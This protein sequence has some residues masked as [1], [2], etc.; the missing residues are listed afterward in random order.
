MLF[1]F[2]FALK[3]NYRDFGAN[4]ST[5]DLLGNTF[6]GECNNLKMQFKESTLFEKLSLGLKRYSLISTDEVIKNA[7]DECFYPEFVASDLASS[8]VSFSRGTH[9]QKESEQF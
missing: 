1:S 7:T 5:I 4:Y 3:I 2:A 8:F 9:N 6:K